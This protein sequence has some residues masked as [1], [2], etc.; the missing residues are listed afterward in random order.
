MFIF[1]FILKDYFKHIYAV[2]NKEL[3]T[4]LK[5]EVNFNTNIL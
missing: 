1:N 3:K 5:D 2:K 4:H